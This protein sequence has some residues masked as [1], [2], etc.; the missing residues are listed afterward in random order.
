MRS[1]LR[2]AVC[3]A[4]VGSLFA[5][6][7]VVSE[8]EPLQRPFERGAFELESTFGMN[9]SLN[10][11]NRPTLNYF[12]SGYRLGW[13]LSSPAGAGCLRGNWEF[14]PQI[15]AARVTEGPGNA[16]GGAALM[17]RRNFLQPSCR[18]SP[19]IQAGGG[20]VYNDIYQEH[21]QRLIGQAWEFDLEAAMGLRYLWSERWSVGLEANFRHISNA[22]LN[23]R[24]VGLNSLGA[25]LT[26]SLHF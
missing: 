17:L 14:L 11:K 25:V 23:E 1:F 9:Y 3:L 20:M 7:R 2:L 24:N 12:D 26:W 10:G 22:N 13:M 19:Y 5:G 8:V 16:F 21:N 6:P 18:W 4:S 15:F